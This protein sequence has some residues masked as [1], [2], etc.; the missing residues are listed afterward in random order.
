MDFLYSSDLIDSL[1]TIEKETKLSIFSY[2]KE[3]SFL[4]KL[5]IEGNWEEAENFLLPLKVNDNFEYSK[6][7]SLLKMQKIYETIETRSVDLDQEKIIEQLKDI[8]NYLTE[9]EFR[10]LLGLLNKNT[11]KEISKLSN[12]TVNRGR[13]KTFDNIKE[14]FW[15]IYSKGKNDERIIKNNLLKNLLHKIFGNQNFNKNELAS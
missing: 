5:I 6:A 1:I 7:I 12:W 8:K 11:I 4:R 15:I 14:L 13:L 9:E 3:L 2:N 10:N